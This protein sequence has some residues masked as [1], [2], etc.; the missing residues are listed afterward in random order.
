[1]YF[2]KRERKEKFNNDLP[3]I[4]KKAGV[5][6]AGAMDIPKETELQTKE[7]VNK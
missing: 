1:L 7:S 2:I 5:H 4:I 3:N 6:W